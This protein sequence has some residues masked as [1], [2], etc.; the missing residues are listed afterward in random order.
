MQ[1]ILR[2]S[3]RRRR[4]CELGHPLAAVPTYAQTAVK[5]L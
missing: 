3:G 4:E 2:V 1:T 5:E